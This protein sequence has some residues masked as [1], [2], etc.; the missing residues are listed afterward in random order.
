MIGDYVDLK[1]I[2]IFNTPYRIKLKGYLETQ[3]QGVTVYI[4]E[5]HGKMYAL[6]LNDN[7]ENFILHDDLES[8][9]DLDYILKIA[10][11]NFYADIPFVID[12]DPFLLD[13]FTSNVFRIEKVEMTKYDRMLTPMVTLKDS[14]I[15]RDE[16][17]KELKECISKKDLKNKIFNINPPTLEKTSSKEEVTRKAPTLED[18]LDN[19]KTIMDKDIET[20]KEIGV[21]SKVVEQH[22]KDE[23]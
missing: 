11:R 3:Y 12:N 6:E 1:N 9:D 21:L 4:L 8:P 13:T 15:M 23:R 10:S 2:E 5:T 14:A 19:F 18:L 22:T 7:H 20:Q 16:T 17:R